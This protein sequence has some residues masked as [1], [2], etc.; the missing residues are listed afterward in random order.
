MAAALVEVSRACQERQDYLANWGS[1]GTEKRRATRFLPFGPGCRFSSLPNSKN[2]AVDIS[3]A[4]SF[5]V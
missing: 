4:C 1:S 3:Y 5:P 2:G